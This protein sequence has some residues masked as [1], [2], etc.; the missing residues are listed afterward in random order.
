[1]NTQAIY[2]MA[3]PGMNLAIFI[4]FMILEFIANM[5]LGFGAGVRGCS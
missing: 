1:M 3:G 5:C 4:V 2:V